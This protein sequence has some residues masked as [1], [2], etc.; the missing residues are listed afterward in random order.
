MKLQMDEFCKAGYDNA[1]RVWAPKLGAPWCFAALV[2]PETSQ[3]AAS[4]LLE[5]LGTRGDT[6]RVLS[7]EQMIKIYDDVGKD[8]LLQ[9]TKVW[10]WEA[11]GCMGN[12]H[13]LAKKS[14][15]TPEELTQLAKPMSR[16]ALHF[17]RRWVSSTLIEEIS[18]SQAKETKQKNMGEL[19][20]EMRM[21]HL[22]DN[23]YAYRQALRKFMAVA[24]LAKPTPKKGQGSSAN[25]RKCGSKSAASGRGGLMLT[26][27]ALFEHFRLQHELSERYTPAAMASAQ[28][29]SVIAAN[30]ARSAAAAIFAKAV[31]KLAVEAEA[32]LPLTAQPCSAAMKAEADA[33]TKLKT[34]E[35][36][37][38]AVLELLLS[39]QYWGGGVVTPLY[40]QISE[41]ERSRDQYR[42]WRGNLGGEDE[43]QS[44]CR[45]CESRDCTNAEERRRSRGLFNLEWEDS[46]AAAFFD[47]GSGAAQKKAPSLFERFCA[48]DDS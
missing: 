15:R 6:P 13:N 27:N 22:S 2:H 24:K 42:V 12:L 9:W 33:A 43:R 18:F 11:T 25:K 26:R 3:K 17:A 44:A 31:P 1:M 45:R 48:A 23:A 38:S 39:K 32:M 30:S 41:G 21:H 14:F 10:S 36:R 34:P 40:T 7:D 29:T 16:W 46:A 35:G 5:V 47:G 20:L 28:K 8:K 4:A 19:A 37:E